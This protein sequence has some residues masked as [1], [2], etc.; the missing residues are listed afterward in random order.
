[1]TISLRDKQLPDRQAVTSANFGTVN[2]GAEAS[3]GTIFSD[4]YRYG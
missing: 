3:R 4:G 2:G 1:M